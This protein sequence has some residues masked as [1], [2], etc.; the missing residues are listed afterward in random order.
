M[1]TVIAARPGNCVG[2]FSCEAVCSFVHEGQ[3]KPSL[4]RIIVRKNN[5]TD[6]T[7]ITI[8]EK[9]DLCEG[10]IECVR[11]CPAGVFKIQE[12]RKGASND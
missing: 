1:R 3:I 10:K 5:L 4:S 9:C 6:E 12:E 8:T 2:C 11:W 7:K